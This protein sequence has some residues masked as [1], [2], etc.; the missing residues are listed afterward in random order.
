[1]KYKDEAIKVEDI[2]EE[3]IEGVF[4]P[5]NEWDERDVHDFETV[6]EE[7][8]VDKVLFYC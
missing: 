6:V 7:D 5:L 1:L 2:K 8:N 4:D 3:V